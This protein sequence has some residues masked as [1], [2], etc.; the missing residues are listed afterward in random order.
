MFLDSGRKEVV[1]AL[2]V[3]ILVPISNGSDEREAIVT[4]NLFQW[5][6][7]IRV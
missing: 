1:L 3:E 6:F 4:G 2:V 5:E 7:G